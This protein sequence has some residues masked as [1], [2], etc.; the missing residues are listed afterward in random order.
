MAR[1]SKDAYGAEGTT[2]LLSFDPDKLVLVEDKNSP[3]YDPR[4]DLPLD[5]AMVNSILT[6]GV[7]EPVLVWK[8]PE[9]GQVK[10]VAGRQ[11]VKNAREANKRLRDRGQ[12]PIFVPGV[13]RR[14]DSKDLALVMIVENEIRED[15]TPVGRAQK[16]QR[17]LGYGHP[18]DK[19]ATVFGVSIQTVKLSLKLLECCA[20][21][22]KAVDDGKINLGH[23][24]ALADLP[25][26]EQKA[27]VEELIAA[28]ESLKGHEKSRKQKAIVND[29]PR[30]KTKKEIKAELETARGARKAALEWVLGLNEESEE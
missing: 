26:E 11:R 16:M 24:R 17:L 25:P 18:E 2:S 15:D 7:Q 1:N 20:A 30:M 14:G 27:K 13:V 3:L 28:G 8:D 22:R 21:V 6:L 9:D 5:E 4:I 29:G 19:I 23:A 12:P 10:V